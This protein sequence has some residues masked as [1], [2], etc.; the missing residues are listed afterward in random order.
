MITAR[1]ARLKTAAVLL[2]GAILVSCSDTPSEGPPEEAVREMLDAQKAG[3]W[4][5]AADYMDVD[6][7]IKAVEEMI[8]NAPNGM[9]KDVMRELEAPTSDKVTFRRIDEMKK[10]MPAGDFTF[11]IV[12]TIDSRKDSATVIVDIT[13]GGKTVRKEFPVV[14]VDGVWK[15]GFSKDKL[16]SGK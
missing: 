10:E 2:V 13:S 12:E 4:Q 16:V 6:G 5:K 11:K 14:K 8:E 3:D 9:K 1:K 15:V 7:M